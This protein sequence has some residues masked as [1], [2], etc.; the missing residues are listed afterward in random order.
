M[1]FYKDAQ[2]HHPTITSEIVRIA[3]RMR[4]NEPL[5]SVPDTSLRTATSSETSLLKG[6]QCR[7]R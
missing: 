1:E 4:S 7:S 3:K 6:V 2:L 5:I